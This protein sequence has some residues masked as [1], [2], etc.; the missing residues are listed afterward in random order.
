MFNICWI[1]N[2]FIWCL[3]NFTILH[4]FAIS[5]VLSFI[6]Y[7]SFFQRGF[8]KIFC[9]NVISF[10]RGIADHRVLRHFQNFLRCEHKLNIKKSKEKFKGHF[11]ERVNVYLKA[12]VLEH[13]RVLSLRFDLARFVF[14][15]LNQFFV[16]ARKWAKKSLKEF[17]SVINLLTQRNCWMIWDSGLKW[18]GKKK[19]PSFSL[20]SRIWTA[21]RRL[22]KTTV[23]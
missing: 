4:D 18:T 11:K 19:L 17:W 16:Q 15:S 6:M 14:L 12:Q 22:H 13:D 3:N 1:Q 7:I 20:A 5:G 8:W 10:V 21:L 23:T 9:R 2:S